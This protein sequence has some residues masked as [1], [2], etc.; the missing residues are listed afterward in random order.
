MFTLHQDR[1]ADILDEQK[2]EDQS[3]HD[4][5]RPVLSRASPWQHAKTKDY[6]S[7]NAVGYPI[8]LGAQDTIIFKRIMESCCQF[9]IMLQEKDGS[10]GS[11]LD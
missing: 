3:E 10:S 8:V 1:D 9:I 7:L 2:G 5:V 11:G 6:H 4:N